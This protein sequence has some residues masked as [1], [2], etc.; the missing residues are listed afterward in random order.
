MR[1]YSDCLPSA[2]FDD[3]DHE[4]E[5]DLA[6]NSPSHLV[7]DHA[8][9]QSPSLF[10]NQQRPSFPTPLPSQEHI[11]SPPSLT[12]GQNSF[13]EWE[14]LETML[15]SDR[16]EDTGYLLLLLHAL[17]GSRI[18]ELMLVRVQVPRPRWNDFGTERSITALEAGLDQ[19]LLEIVSDTDRFNQTIEPFIEFNT[20]NGSRAFSLKTDV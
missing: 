11:Y 12:P 17:G 8:S 18:S 14:E 7:R 2:D 20:T 4:P 19:Q 1:K 3:S 9:P 6:A 5:R 16:I 13:N 10:S 15:R